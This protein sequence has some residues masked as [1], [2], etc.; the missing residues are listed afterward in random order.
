M[1]VTKCLYCST[2]NLFRV[3]S[4]SD[5]MDILQCPRC[6]VMM[7]A[8]TNNDTESMYTSEYFQKSE[9]NKYGYT[10]YLSSPVA[11][12][13]GK[14]AFTRLFQDSTGVHLDLGCADGSLMEIFRAEG[15]Q[16]YGYEISK[17]AVRIANN[18]QLNVNFSNL[19]KFPELP[20]SADA[21]TAFDL[22]EHVDLPGKT[23]EEI[24]AK[25]A[26]GGYFVFSTLSVKKNNPL[27]HW[28]NNSLEH[29]IY[30]DEP[31]L[32]FILREVFGE[33]NFYFVEIE[34]NGIAEFWGVARKG[35]PLTHEMHLLKG[36]YSGKAKMNDP[37]LMYLESLF[38]N[39]V[40]RFS[41]S[42]AI[43]AR[44]ENEWSAKRTIQAKFYNYYFQGLFAKIVE[45]VRPSINLIPVNDVV[46]WQAYADVVDRMGAITVGDVGKVKDAQIAEVQEKLFDV[47]M[48]ISDLRNSKLIGTAMRVRSKL[49]SA[50]HRILKFKRL[51]ERGIHKLRV[52]TA[53]MV[54]G[55][56]RKKV[57]SAYRMTKSMKE[58][59][60][61]LRV[62]KNNPWTGTDPLVGIVVPF[63]NAKDTIEQTLKSIFSQ[64]F[65]DF[66]VVLIDDGSKQE[67]LE[68]IT[69]MKKM[70]PDLEVIY[71]EQNKGVAAARNTGI[72][73]VSSKYVMCLD[74][75]DWIEP[76]YLEKM[77][78]LLESR[79]ELSLASSNT[80]MFGVKN[81]QIKYVQYDP[82]LLFKNNMVVHAALVRRS[83]WDASSKYRSGIGYEDW[84][85]WIGLA[86]LGY[87]GYVLPETLFNYRTAV[88]SRFID[89]RLA[90]Q[91]N[92]QSIQALHPGYAKKI[93]GITSTRAK[94]K[95]IIDPAT[96]FVNLNN[97]SD[98]ST[99]VGSRE[100][101]LV[102]IP[103]MTFGG[104][105]TLIYNFCK[106]I[107]N[108]FDISFITGLK[109][110]HEW[111]YKF[112]EVSDK[113][114]HLA[115]LFDTPDLYLEF[116]SNYILTHN[117]STLHIVHNG[118]MFDMLGE[119]KRRH[120]QLKVI[121]T[122]FNDRV[123]YFEQSV[124]YSS[125]IDTYTTD[126]SKVK[127]HYVELLGS[128]HQVLTIPNGIDSGTTFKREL[129]DRNDM[130]KQLGL[131]KGDIACF[132]VGRL[133]VEKNPNVFVDAAKRLIDD[134]RAGK[135]RFYIIG[136]GPMKESIT[137]SVNVV[138]SDR[139][140]YL[141]YQSDPAIYLAAADVFILPSSIEGFPL[142]LI[143]AM[144]MELVCIASNVGAV[145]EVLESGKIGFVV[146]PG[147]TDEV[148]GA[149]I[150]LCTNPR[151]LSRMGELARRKVEEKFSS[152][153]LG[154]NYRKLYK[155]ALK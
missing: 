16:T 112:K 61:E 62:V 97:P 114:Y 152:K 88:A 64:S 69:Q 66:R 50:R 121:L 76:L 145:D 57:K 22:L 102:A 6:S 47:N 4:R 111:E 25:L 9:D 99:G 21:I 42:A 149:L 80:Q 126:N 67:S 106:E 124:R 33:K 93:A 154:S 12:L 60:Q 34:N 153:Q 138:S 43:I 31:S 65:R 3:A 17:D 103:W 125:H 105:E 37:E 1:K 151:S 7:V 53:P 30:Y 74:A 139:L 81:D 27:D 28:L 32:S 146:S 109:S 136:D 134:D 87:W 135:L 35:K 72:S 144:A 2:G 63:F 100:R 5:K 118:F 116:V 141:G 29:Y 68:K 48:Q 44:C 8:Q 115:N 129:Y 23:L 40:S 117:I 18:K 51:P 10:D 98:Y 79:P 45:E 131:E 132:F 110:D 36:L 78:L 39:Q 122:M 56:V 84:E 140:Q 77:L 49:G 82:L 83:A 71:H 14:Y 119:V 95:T 155:G 113:I 108:E 24:Y 19:H 142:S 94:T 130:R 13:F 86:E 104:A 96:A 107:C 59:V 70:W 85:Y 55:T 128:D 127:N 92:T 75:D 20:L 137:K 143:E 133:S 101:V 52:V 89:D 41:D 38:L 46:F 90:H 150:K 147:S 120:P 148:V 91:N 54:P 73:S 26:N 15:F 11:N 58:P 123:E